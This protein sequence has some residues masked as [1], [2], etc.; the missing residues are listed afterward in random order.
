[1]K[2]EIRH[3][4][5][6]KKLLEAREKEEIR[7]DPINERNIAKGEGLTSPTNH[8]TTEETKI[9]K[10]YMEQKN[11]FKLT[12]AKPHMKKAL[13]LKRF[14]KM[15]RNQQVEIYSKA[16]QKSIYSEGKVNAIGRDFVMIT[17]LKDRIWIPYEKIDSANVPYGIPNY[18]NTHQHYIYDNDLRTKLLQNF[19]ATVSQRE[20]LI[21]QFHEETLRTNLS[22]WKN[23]WVEIKY[24]ENKSHVGK[25]LET[26]KK[27][28]TL[29]GFRHVYHIPLN[30]I[31]MIETIRFLKILTS[32]IGK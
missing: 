25:V 32:F 3:D 28:V 16:G 19:G 7:I 2:E 18:S 1:V 5:Y 17:N 15:K 8:V 9:F 6:V 11:L 10:E 30:K 21:Q 14:F 26:S 4:E 24:E 13:T 29:K 12:E 31:E 20:I 27:T 22:R 23:T